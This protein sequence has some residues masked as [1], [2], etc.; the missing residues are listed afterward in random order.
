MCKIVGIPPL[1]ALFVITGCAT[2]TVGRGPNIPEALRV[3]PNQTL[4]REVQAV[5]VQIYECQ[6]SKDV[7]P[8]FHWIFKAPE[9]EL[10]NRADIVVGRHYA[11]PTWE[12]ND[13][14]KV[15]GKVVARDSSAD[16]NAIPWLLLSVTSASDR[17]FFSHINSIQRLN[18]SGGNAPATGC[19]ETLAGEETRV[20]YKAEYLF[21][22]SR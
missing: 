6:A 12:A 14:S 18:T 7:L 15:V 3:P 1:V 8:G 22:G 17:G 9:A 10:R 16:P 5:G 2:L 21:Y 4:I 11:G 13:G 19:S 20:P